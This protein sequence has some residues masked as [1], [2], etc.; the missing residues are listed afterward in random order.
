MPTATSD[1]VTITRN[2]N[3]GSDLFFDRQSRLIFSITK[4]SALKKKVTITRV[5]KIG[6]G[7]VIHNYTIVHHNRSPMGGCVA[8]FGCAPVGLGLGPRNG[9]G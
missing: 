1:E 6:S 9:P 7:G 2:K 8:W 4:K 3:A 5:P